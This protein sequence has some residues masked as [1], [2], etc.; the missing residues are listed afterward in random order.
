M[1]KVIE[2]TL[3]TI[4]NEFANGKKVDQAPYVHIPF[5]EAM[6]NYGSDKPDLRNPLVLQN[7]T[8]LFGESGFGVYDNLAK[9]TGCCRRRREAAL[10]L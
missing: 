5:R 6:M 7:V 1:F 2:H 4:F 8:G 10:F 3:G 9:E